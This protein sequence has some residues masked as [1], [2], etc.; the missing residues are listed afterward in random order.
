MCDK[1]TGQELFDKLGFDELMVHKD[2]LIEIVTYGDRN[3]PSNIAI[4]CI[5]CGEVLIDFDKD[6]SETKE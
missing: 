2:H 4:E 6:E 5:I 3:D 1:E